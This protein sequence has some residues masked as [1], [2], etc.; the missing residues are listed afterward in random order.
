MSLQV[1]LNLVL[2]RVYMLLFYFSCDF[3]SLKKIILFIYLQ[4]HWVFFAACGLFLVGESWLMLELRY[5]GFLFQWLLLSWSTDSRALGLQ[6]LQ[7]SGLRVW[8]QYLW[9]MGSAAL[10]MWNLPI[11]ETEPMSPALAGKF[12]DHQGSP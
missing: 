1:W 8:V 4:L 10:G 5:S 3:F 6:Q 7:L 2:S 11:P 9:C 12:L